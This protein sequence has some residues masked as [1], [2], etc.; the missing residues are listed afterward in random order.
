MRF[1]SIL[2]KQQKDIN[3]HETLFINL[4]L[5]SHFYSGHRPFNTPERF[6]GKSKAGLVGEMILEA[7]EIVGRIM[8]ELENQGIADDT[9]IG[10]IQKYF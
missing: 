4:S 7:D 3:L 9:L 6:R 1:Y 10:M 5:F 8:S 2:L